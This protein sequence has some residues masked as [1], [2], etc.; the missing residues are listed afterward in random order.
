MIPGA[1]LVI[2]GISLPETAKGLDFTPVEFLPVASMW[3]VSIFMY[4]Y[5]G[6]I[7]IGMF[8]YMFISILRAIFEKDKSRIPTLPVWIMTV[9]MSLY[10]IF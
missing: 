3:L 9:L 8:V 1:A 2:V 6:G 10:Y 7:V 5:V 4:D